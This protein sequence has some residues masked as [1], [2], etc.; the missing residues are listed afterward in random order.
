MIVITLTDC[1]ISLRGDLSKW[2][3]EINTG[4]FVGKLS[5]R[6]RDQLWKRVKD[7]VKNGRATMV[8]STNNEQRMDFRIHNSQNQIIDFDGLKLVMKPS[9]S[10]IKQLE[11][12][13]RYFSKA[14]QMQMG[15]K[16][17]YGVME[18][19]KTNAEVKKYPSEYVV[20]DL[21]TT[22]LREKLDEIIEIGVLK[23]SDGK[24]VD[25]FQSLV[26]NKRQLSHPIE[27]I[28]GITQA[29]L[30]QSGRQMEEI[31]GDVKA[32]IGNHCIVGHNISFDMRFLNHTLEKAGVMKLD[33]LQYDTMRMYAEKTTGA[34]MRKSLVD[35]VN[36][37]GISEKPCHRSMQ[38]CRA[39]MAVYEVLRQDK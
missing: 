9:V 30:H 29:M 34:N 33:N 14:A 10:R 12:K 1:P 31:I 6:V 26:K 36:D 3:I 15:Q 8:Y 25:M 23:V 38:D 28:T 32:F 17:K 35:I 37:L 18:G 5:A 7:N 19:D 13:R 16:R 20:L 27:K 22:G 4:V 24:V 39:V 11:K 21:E 2:L